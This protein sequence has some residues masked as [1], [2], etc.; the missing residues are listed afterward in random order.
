MKDHS[1]TLKIGALARRTR[2]S[3]P[4]IRY[5]EQIGLLPRARRQDGGQRRYG[6]DDVRRLTFIRRCREF[7]FPIKQVKGLV[8]LMQDRDRSC[9]EARDAARRHLV[10]VRD[11]LVELGALER[12]LAAFV[13]ACDQSCAGG[14][15]PDCPILEDLAG[16]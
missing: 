8:T 12:G 6:E 16:S 2:T 11:K 5:Y 15:A 13:R 1:V 14:A 9:L 4:T 7:D 3:P 10:V